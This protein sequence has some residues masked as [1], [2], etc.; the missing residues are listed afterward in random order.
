MIYLFSLRMS[1]THWEVT[2]VG[3][4]GTVNQLQIVISAC[5]K[6]RFWDQGDAGS[7][8]VH[9][10]SYWGVSVGSVLLVVHY[11][12]CEMSELDDLSHRRACLWR[13]PHGSTVGLGTGNV[14]VAEGEASPSGGQI[15]AAHC[16][17][18]GWID[19][20]VGLT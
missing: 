4:I 6:V 10:P 3:D 17:G 19:T 12:K 14:R 13:A 16:L 9:Q 15:H 11:G 5:E 1:P 2:D 18:K 8:R 7:V 20:E